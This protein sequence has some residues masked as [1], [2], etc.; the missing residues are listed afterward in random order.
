MVDQS[1]RNLFELYQQNAEEADRQIFGRVSYPDRRGFLK[2]AGLTAMAAALGGF[3]PFHRFMP[4]GLIP[5]AIADGTIELDIAGKDG[6]RVLNDRPINA[7]TPA[8]LLDADITPINR[9]FVRNNGVPPKEVNVDEWTLTI[10]GEVETPMTFT[11]AELKEQFEVVELALQIECGGNGRAGFNPPAKGNQWSTGAIG[12]SMW[13]GVRLKDVL[14][15]AGVKSTAVYTGNL[16][17]DTH[18]S[19]DASKAP[20]SR[21]VPIAKALD[22]HN[23]IAFQQNGE[24]IHPMNGAPLRLVT[25]GWP[26]SCSQKWLTGIVLSPEKWTGTKMAPPSYSVPAF[27][28]QPGAVVEDKDF[29]TFESMPVKSLITSP[30]TGETLSP[31]QKSLRLRGH[32]WAGDSTVTKVELS[33]DFG[34]SWVEAP[35]AP[36]MNPFSWATWEGE[37]SFPTHGYYEIWARATDD[38]GKVQPFSVAWNPKGYLNN[39]MHRIAVMVPQA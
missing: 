23:I 8:H 26:G 37:V 22:P 2:G 6:L 31:G 17:A 1:K 15:K 29:V 39:A 21:G 4:A 11:I 25:P 34:N 19:G 28:V 24:D 27:P 33:N 7:E 35:L 12:N 20:M 10:S 18:L 9:H 3:I 36:L 5:A 30:Q 13:K 32:A 16:G 14:E 38:Q